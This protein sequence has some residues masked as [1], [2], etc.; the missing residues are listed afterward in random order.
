MLKLVHSRA[1]PLQKTTS[2]WSELN[3]LGAENQSAPVSPAPSEAQAARL[4][5]RSAN[6]RV[7][8]RTN[9]STVTVRHDYISRFSRESFCAACLEALN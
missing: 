4:H 9:G 7:L 1:L 3:I 5:I 8:C 6:D 2:F